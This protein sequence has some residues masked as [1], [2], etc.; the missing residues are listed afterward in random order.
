[1]NTTNSLRSPGRGPLKRLN[2]LNKTWNSEVGDFIFLHCKSPG[3]PKTS[4]IPMM[5]LRN[6]SQ[7]LP[8]TKI[9]LVSRSLP[10]RKLVVGCLTRILERPDYHDPHGVRLLL[11]TTLVLSKG[12]WPTI[13][14]FFWV[15]T[16]CQTTRDNNDTFYLT[17]ENC[18]WGERRIW[19]GFPV[20][21]I[22]CVGHPSRHL[23]RE[24]VGY[25][26][27]SFHRVSYLY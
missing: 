23:L 1:M 15:R 22:L 11:R 17:T 6:V 16:N 12:C 18:H 7:N 10:R 25:T 14:N 27:L 20:T 4:P 21:T 9:H 19:L 24:L 3:E 2:T 8:T 26:H 5:R 13:F